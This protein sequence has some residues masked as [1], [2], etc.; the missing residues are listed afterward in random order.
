MIDITNYH[1]KTMTGKIYKILP[2]F[3]EENEG[4]TTYISSLI[5]ELEGLSE[6]VDEKQNSM[7]Q[8]IIDVLEHVYNDSLAPNPDINIVRREILNCTNLFQKMFERSGSDE[9]PWTL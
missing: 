4:L 5:Y 2:L 3:Q 7:L 8:T 1:I 9:L 6:R